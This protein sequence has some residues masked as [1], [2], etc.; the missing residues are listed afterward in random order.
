MTITI[1]ST[2]RI[3]CIDGVPVRLWEGVTDRGVACKVF[4]HRVAVHGEED[5]SQF[6]AELEETLQP[7]QG[8]PLSQIL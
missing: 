3:T 8:A 4:V 1:S 2:E 6:E 7:G 5:A